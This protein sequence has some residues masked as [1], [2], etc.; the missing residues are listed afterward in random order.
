MPYSFSEKSPTAM[1]LLVSELK[2]SSYR[3]VRA[4][5]LAASFPDNLYL[6]NVQ[7]TLSVFYPVPCIVS[8][9]KQETIQAR[10]ELFSFGVELGISP[11]RCLLLFQSGLFFKKIRLQRQLVRQLNCPVRLLNLA[12]NK[13]L[14][15]R[16]FQ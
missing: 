1:A 10:K 4:R 6:V 11:E 13:K 12:D 9:W 15:T 14:L 3:F 7:P 8:A 5:T 16:G 2:T